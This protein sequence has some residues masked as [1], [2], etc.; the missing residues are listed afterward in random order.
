[1]YG[2]ALRAPKSIIRS[3]VVESSVC[4]IRH[5]SRHQ[6]WKTAEHSELFSRRRRQSLLCLGSPK[7][8]MSTTTASATPDVL[9]QYV[10]LRRD[11]WKELQWPL[12]SI[13]AQG[14]HAA[15][16]A[17]WL[18]KDEPTTQTYCSPEN[19]NSMHKVLS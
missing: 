19:I 9:L 12:G 2:F 8:Q 3:A 18:S 15:T 13:V 4:R 1:M 14:C 10:I 11:L 6:H 17:L 7:N 16:A 5:Q